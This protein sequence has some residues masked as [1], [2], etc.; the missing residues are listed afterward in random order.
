MRKSI[1]GSVNSG[2]TYAHAMGDALNVAYAQ[3][4]TKFNAHIGQPE[5][6]LNAETGI[7]AHFRDALV[8][9]CASSMRSPSH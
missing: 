7:V 2:L 3:V 1:Y 6:L 8:A 9:Q 5:H 4:L